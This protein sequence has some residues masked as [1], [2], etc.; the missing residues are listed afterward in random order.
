MV[1]RST[2]RKN[3]FIEIYNNLNKLDD[4]LD[5]NKQWIFSSNPDFNAPSFV[6]FPLIVLNVPRVSKTYD[7]VQDENPINYVTMTINVMSKD[8]QTLDTLSD[9][10]DAMMD[11]IILKNYRF[12]D[13]SES[14][15]DVLINGQTIHIRSMSYLLDVMR[16]V[17]ND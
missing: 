2:L 15:N 9:S 11:S 14:N 6:G 13:F 4:P 8:S 5:R 1:E 10:V 17:S 3:V 16:Y 7:R 12:V